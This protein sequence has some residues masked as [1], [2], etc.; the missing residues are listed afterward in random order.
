MQILLYLLNYFSIFRA[1]CPSSI[2]AAAPSSQSRIRKLG[3]SGSGHPVRHQH[4]DFHSEPAANKYSVV[5]VNNNGI[6]AGNVTLSN[7]G[8]S[9]PGVANINQT[10]RR[11]HSSTTRNT[12]SQSSDPEISEPPV[13]RIS[14]PF[15][16]NP[17]LKK[18]SK[19]MIWIHWIFKLMWIV[20]ILETTYLPLCNLLSEIYTYQK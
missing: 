1:L 15:R 8:G 2:S 17:I 14:V 6:N 7:L 13:L 20:I 10:S 12:S 4:S 3:I 18:N 16:N 19:N 5:F 11:R 9:E